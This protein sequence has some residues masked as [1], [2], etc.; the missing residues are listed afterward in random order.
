MGMNPF[1][2]ISPRIP[3]TP[4]PTDGDEEKDDANI[5][6]AETADSENDTHSLLEDE[7]ADHTG[8]PDYP[9]IPRNTAVTVTGTSGGKGI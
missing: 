5:V 4:I 1:R 7:T 3:A 2:Q 8:D 6:E 9:A